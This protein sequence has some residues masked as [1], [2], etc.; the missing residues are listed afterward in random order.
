MAITVE[1]LEN[2]Q[3]RRKTYPYLGVA[4]NNKSVVLFTSPRTGV[5]LDLGGYKGHGVGYICNTW[6]EDSFEHYEG[7]ILL[8]NP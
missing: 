5:L 2:Q 7:S 1:R 6:L 8:T 3:L 4:R